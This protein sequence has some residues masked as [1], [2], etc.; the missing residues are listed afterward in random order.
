MLIGLYLYIYIYILIHSVYYIIYMC[1]WCVNIHI[2]YKYM[3]W[4]VVQIPFWILCILATLS[5]SF[6]SS[7]GF[8]VSSKGSVWE[9]NQR[10]HLISARG[11]EGWHGPGFA[12]SV[13]QLLRKNGA[14]KM[15]G[16]GSWTFKACLNEVLMVLTL[17]KLGQPMALSCPLQ[18][19]LYKSY[20][21]YFVDAGCL[22]LL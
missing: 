18:Q 22:H 1:V 5:L 19:R 17:V 4:D 6:T 9:A 15:A 8:Q 14:W 11:D 20:N 7:S 16:R 12:V 13:H 21:L 3:Q 2:I 10:T